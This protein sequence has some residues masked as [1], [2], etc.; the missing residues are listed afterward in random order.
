MKL[1]LRNS[2]FFI[3]VIL[4]CLSS[5]YGYHAIKLDAKFERVA[6]NY[7]Y[8]IMGDSQMQRL[9]VEAFPK[10]TFNFS[11]VAEHYCFTYYKLKKLFD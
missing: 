7:S 6:A 4:V 2:C 9:P 3:C 8:L 1:F 5:I 10:K 11:N